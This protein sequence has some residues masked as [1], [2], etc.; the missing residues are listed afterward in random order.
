M[1]NIEIAFPN[2]SSK[3][4]KT[5]LKNTYKHYGMVLFDFLRMPNLNKKNI[6]DL[7]RLDDKSKKILNDCNGGIIMTGHLGNWE[8]F[9]PA[10]G[11]NGFPFVVVTQTQKN[12]GSQ[13][14]FNFIRSFP[15]VSLIPRTGA[16]K[17]M[18][19][20]LEENKYLGLASDQNAGEHGTE[21]PFF[22]KP[23]STPR[24]TALFHL[25]TG[26]PIIV[27]F[28]ILSSDLKYDLKLRTMKVSNNSNEQNQKVIDINTDF[29]KTL[30]R[31]IRSFPEQ[32][33]WFHRKWS[34]SIYT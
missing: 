4:I 28:C 7:V 18:L 21:I 11:L 14:F 27:G 32:Y 5:L 30:E 24:G 34:R 13:K 2:Y 6:R 25:K 15:N 1:Q 20:V 9:L 26:M 8:L 29:C 12:P 3:E 31:E 23:V 16:R 33:F 10:L 19:R 17:K 22:D